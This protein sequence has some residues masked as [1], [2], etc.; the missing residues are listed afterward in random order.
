MTPQYGIVVSKLADDKFNKLIR[1]DRK[2]GEQ[3]A[4]AID[5]LASNPDLG[6]MLKGEWKGHRKYR[7]GYYRII[8]RLERENLSSIS[9]R[10]TIAKMCT[11]SR[12]G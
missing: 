6:E 7:T 8:Y 12:L 11:D 5:R 3:V 1:A 2:L 9:S 4:K 10:L